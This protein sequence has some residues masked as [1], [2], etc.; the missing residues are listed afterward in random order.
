MAEPRETEVGQVKHGT[1]TRRLL[2]LALVLGMTLA[3]PVPARAEDDATTYPQITI[4]P[5]GYVSTPDDQNVADEDKEKLK[6]RFWAYQIFT[7]ELD[8]GEMGYDEDAEINAL[9]NVHWGESITNQDSLMD[10]LGEDPTPARDLGITFALMLETGDYYLNTGSESE[11]DYSKTPFK[12]YAFEYQNEKYWINGNLTAAGWAALDAALNEDLKT[13]TIGDVFTFA[14]DKNVS[15]DIVTQG[16]H[17]ASKII[18]DFTPA[19]GNVA[20]A[21]AFYAIVFDREEYGDEKPGKYKYLDDNPFQTSRWVEEGGYWAIGEWDGGNINNEPAGHDLYLLPGYYMIRDAYSEAGN[22]G[23]AGAAYMAAVYGHGTIDPKAEAPTVTKAFGDGSTGSAKGASYEPGEPIYFTLRGTLP[24]NYYTGY[25][26]YPYIFEDTLPEGLTFGGIVRVYVRN[27]GGLVHNYYLIEEAVEATGGNQGVGYRLEKELQTDGTTKITVSFPNLKN[28]KARS[29]R[30]STWEPGA[31]VANPI[32]GQSEI[33]VVYTAKLNENANITDIE[34]SGNLNTVKLRYANEPLW[35]PAAVVNGGTWD[36]AWKDAPTGYVSAFV[37]AYDFGVQLTVYDREDA[38]TEKKPLAG[39]G[40]ALTKTVD[41][42]KYYAILQKS[43]DTCYVAGWVSE[44]DLMDY[45][46]P[47]GGDLKSWGD[48]LKAGASIGGYNV[49]AGGD[50]YV[51]VKT[52]AEDG[53]VRIVGQKSGVGYVLR[54]VITPAGYDPVGDISVEFTAGYDN[55]SGV[56]ENL[57]A[58]AHGGVEATES[59]VAGRAYQ[60]EYEELVAR[61]TVGHRASGEELVETGGAGTTL[62]Y[63]GGGALLLGAALFLVLPNVKKKRSGK[64][65]Q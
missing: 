42:K 48:Q 4:K 9:K 49:P 13:V 10:A 57:S 53:I 21:R 55:R 56:L 58:D 61:L 47:D 62:F 5:N 11:P 26:G 20:L 16:A 27:S 65:D 46:Y 34:A 60:G 64:G 52:T 51:A 18:A 36:N 6:T 23:K 19:T 59:V 63:V 22:E 44:D 37:R 50:Y 32:T 25:D 24:E 17:T 35:D 1:A 12:N 31:E 33:F 45:L 39:A 38:T 41:G 7:G 3:L 8:T 30:Q 29:T 28:V 40:F 15:N 2:A 14:L 54:E 43:G